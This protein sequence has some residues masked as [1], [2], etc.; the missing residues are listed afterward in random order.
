MIKSNI[1]NLNTI[2]VQGRGHL[3]TDMDGETVIMSIQNSKYYNL[4][5]PGSF[6]WALLKAPIPIYTIIEELCS[7]YAVEPLVCEEQVFSFLAS[8]Y[9][10]CLITIEEDGS[11]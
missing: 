4:G 5:E 10:E 7:E 11:R 1:F 2:V 6:I 9:K 8:L 3:V